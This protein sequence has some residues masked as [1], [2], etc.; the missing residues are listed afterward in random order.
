MPPRIAIPE[1]TSDEP[2]YNQRSLPQYIAAV[3]AAGAEAVVIHLLD[4]QQSVAKLLASVQ[5][6]LLPGSGHDVDPQR[7]GEARVPE[8][9]SDDPMR[10]AADELL[11]RDAFNLRKPILAICHGTQTLNVWCGGSLIQD[12]KTPVNHMPGRDV[13]EAHP[14]TIAVGSRLTE[15]LVH[16]GESNAQVNS[17]HHQAIRAAGNNLSVAAISPIDGVIEAVE[18]DAPDHFVVGVQW[19]PE[20][21]YSQSEFSREIFS[22]FVQSAA[23]WQAPQ[24]ESKQGSARR[25]E[26]APRQDF[27]TD[28]SES[29][30][31]KADSIK[32][33]VEGAGS[34][35]NVL[36]Q[37]AGLNPLDDET[38]SQFD[39]YLS[40]FVRWNQH[41]NLSSVRGEEEIL[42]RHFVESIAV[43]QSIPPKI[44]M[45]LDFGSGGGLPGIPIAL[46]RPQICVTLAESQGKKAAFLQEAVRVLGIAAKVHAGRAETLAE[47]PVARFDCP[48]FDC[49]VLRAVEKMP[50]AVAVAARLVA[51]DG[52]LA[53]M[54]TDI[55]LAELQAAAG[56]HFSWQP[57]IRLPGSDSRILAMGQRINS[58]I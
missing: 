13:V 15:I 18:L 30:K 7:Y 22:A 28:V 16:S 4:P 17:S 35:L 38:I 5:G 32:M 55:R 27:M 21:T 52:W 57:P 51:P 11:L 54:T 39:V 50:T 45:L 49:V 6:I 29:E 36:L 1:P 31:S 46:C 33:T 3:E 12:L 14:V 58:Q 23:A 41:L 9:A 20:R 37:A 25:Q 43:A 26:S 2:E 8:T 10:T 56:S 34:R 42:S 53:L 48:V 19:H 44:T 47:T 24:Q 40:L